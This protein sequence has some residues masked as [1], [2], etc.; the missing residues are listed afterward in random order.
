MEQKSQKG[1]IY[2]MQNPTRN[3][4][5]IGCVHEPTIERLRKRWQNLSLAQGELLLVRRAVRVENVGAIEKMLHVTF[6]PYRLKG[7]GREKFDI[8][9]AQFCSVMHALTNGKGERDIADFI[10]KTTDA[11][12]KYRHLDP[13]EEKMWGQY[14]LDITADP[15]NEASDDQNVSLDPFDDD[16]AVQ[17]DSHDPLDS[18][19]SFQRS[20]RRPSLSYTELGLKHGDV[21]THNR[22]ESVTVTIADPDERL[23]DFNGKIVPISEATKDIQ[24][25]AGLTSQV[26]P[27]NYW[28]HNGTLLSVKAEDAWKDRGF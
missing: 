11:V 15:C 14:N 19:E 8:K 28:R 27:D 2:G 16:S 7:M 6:E 23:V 4:V 17:G 1:I 9:P 3:W 26:R 24:A 12:S 20:S 10:K 18:E 13:Y 21:L 25:D 5:K 22:N